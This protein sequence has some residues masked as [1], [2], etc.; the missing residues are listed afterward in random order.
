MQYR[1]FL[2]EAIA[3]HVKLRV[4]F[5]L[6]FGSIDMLTSSA[7]SKLKEFFGEK[8]MHN[9]SEHALQCTNI[10]VPSTLVAMSLQ[11]IIETFPGTVPI[12]ITSKHPSTALKKD[13]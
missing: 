12:K 9:I 11:K 13:V 6:S 7:A 4:L 1:Q 8:Q 5:D 3:Q 2:E 10:V